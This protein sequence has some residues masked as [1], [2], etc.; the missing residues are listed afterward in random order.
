[1]VKRMVTLCLSINSLI[2]ALSSS[3][4][5]LFFFFRIITVC[6]VLLKCCLMSDCLTICMQLLA[7]STHQNNTQHTREYPRIFFI[8]FFTSFICGGGFV[9]LIFFF[10]F[11]FLFPSKYPTTKIPVFHTTKKIFF[12]NFNYFLKIFISFTLSLFRLSTPNIQFIP[13]FCFSFCFILI[14]E[15]FSNHNPSTCSVCV[16]ALF[17]APL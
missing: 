9:W 17:R 10:F 6:A 5:L 12:K 8:Y 2:L 7:F 4:S 16:C 11:V 15:M 14:V 3:L 13:L 1:M